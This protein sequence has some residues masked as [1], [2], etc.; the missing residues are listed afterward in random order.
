MEGTFGMVLACEKVVAEFVDCV[1]ASAGG[2]WLWV[3]WEA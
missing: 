3:K 1:A 2:W